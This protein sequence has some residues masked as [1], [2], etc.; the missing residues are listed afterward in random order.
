MYHVPCTL[1][2]SSL[3]ESCLRG[4]GFSP[5]ILGSGEFNAQGTNL[6]VNLMLGFCFVLVCYPGEQ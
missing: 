5:G 6:L 3:P 4:I 2:V 1:M